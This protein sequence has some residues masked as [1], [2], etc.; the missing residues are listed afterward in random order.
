MKKIFFL[1]VPYTLCLMPCALS[2]NVGIGTTTP[3]RAKLEVNGAVGATTAIFGGESTGI[4]IQRNWPSIGFNQ[5]YNGGSK[6][7][8]GGY[9]AVQYLDPG[10]GA[11]FIDMFPS[12]AKDAI[13]S[14][15]TR[16]I[17]I[18]SSG[19]VGIRTTPGNASLTVLKATNFE[20]SAVF[21]GT[22]YNSHFN[23]GTSED[24][25]IRGGKTG[26]KVFI[27]DIPGG[28]ILLGGGSSLVSINNGNPSYPLEIREIN[29]YGPIFV[30]PNNS[31]NNWEMRLGL[32]APTSAGPDLFMVY[33]GQYKCGFQNG[34]GYYYTFS[35]KRLKTNIR[36]LP[37]ILDKFMKL[38]PVEYEMKDN[39]P[40]GKT[41]IGFIA[42]NVQ[43]LFPELVTVTTNTPHGYAGINELYGINY[44]GFRILAI[45]ALQ[46]QQEKI[47]KM[48]QRNTELKKRIAAVEAIISGQKIVNQSSN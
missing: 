2:Q 44:N 38:A 12:G 11:M 33:N 39:N 24:T 34:N 45:E 43:K 7:I 42:Q 5:Y 47:G 3:S 32:L 13:A 20:G 41:T 30:E 48:Q 1:L 27:N 6:Y 26:S 36:N 10:S 28:K 37:G 16:P 40:A 21:G 29:E 19:N 22:N 15:L 14:S 31:Y 23:Y 46:E 35:D 4:S 18:N 25:Y 9:G 17:I 8:A